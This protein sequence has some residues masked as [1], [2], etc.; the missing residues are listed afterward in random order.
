MSDLTNCLDEILTDE[1][2]NKI[3]PA[4][5]QEKLLKLLVEYEESGG[6]GNYLT[7]E[8]TIS[9]TQ[10][11]QRS[12]INI[13][14]N[15][16]V[17]FGKISKWYAD[18]KNVAFTGSYN[19]LSNRPTIPSKTSQLTNDSN[20]LKKSDVVDSLTTVNSSTESG[21]P[22]GIQAVKAV[23]NKFGGLRFGIDGDGNYGYYGADDSLIPFNR[24]VVFGNF[25]LST[26]FQKITLGFKPRF[27]LVSTSEYT[28]GAVSYEYDES[29]STTNVKRMRILSTTSATA[30]TEAL[31]TYMNILDDGFSFKAY[32]SNYSNNRTA[33]YIAF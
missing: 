17:L 9:F 2:G 32:S 28:S 11:S 23:N 4:C 18:L 7:E 13:T 22:V 25:S 29:Y 26:S 21:K 3:N 19:D 20:F 12:N 5:G 6:G 24:S 30:G 31:G 10:A 1:K 14:D 27:L 15:I 8:S 33:H 16:K